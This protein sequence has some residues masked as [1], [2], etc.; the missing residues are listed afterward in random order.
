MPD[1]PEV[2]GLLAL[3]LLQES[4]REA[5]VAADGTLAMLEEQDRS[6]WDSAIL[7][8]GAALAQKAL[9][10]RRV[11]AFQLQAATA[12]ETDWAQIA[13]IYDELFA[14]QPTPVVAL[15][16]AAAHGMAHGPQAGLRLL[17]AIEESEALASYYLLPAA[18][19][20]LLRRARRH[21]EA[22]DAYRHA[23][24]LCTNLVE[25]RYLERRLAEVTAG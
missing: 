3:M 20:D 18:R 1:E 11:G 24:D 14:A 22:A 17:D 4:R 5:R 12:A 10:M 23:I 8:E 25:R 16:R 6:L 21:D 13:A 2:L 7:E 9:R 19:A 15:N